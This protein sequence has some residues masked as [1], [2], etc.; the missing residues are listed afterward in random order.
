M[1]IRTDNNQI[2]N[3]KPIMNST[4]DF[5]M[6]IINPDWKSSRPKLTTEELNI[7]R[8]DDEGK[9]SCVGDIRPGSYVNIDDLMSEIDFFS[10][11]IRLSNYNDEDIEK[12]RWYASFGGDMAN[13][14]YTR[15]F[16]KCF[17]EVAVISE[18][19]Q[20]RRGFLRKML[21]TIRQ[22]SESKVLEPQK[23]S[24]WTGKEKNNGGN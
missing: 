1:D 18:T 15:A 23:K 11:D 7:I 6:E 12:A 10:R 17:Q 24:V 21:N 22:E 5:N 19:S 16:K 4:L 8:I 14:G 9:L 20:G 3:Q 13:A 2:V